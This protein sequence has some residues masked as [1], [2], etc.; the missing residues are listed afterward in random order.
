M[1]KLAIT[2]ALGTMSGITILGTGLILIFIFN[3]QTI[4]NI[5]MGT[6]IVIV[7]LV[8][9]GV[10]GMLLVAW[11]MDKFDALYNYYSKTNHRKGGRID[12][13]I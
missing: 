9:A 10:I 8:V 12:R 4:F 11:I 6:F 2:K 5:I 3:P 13:L 7:C 1:N